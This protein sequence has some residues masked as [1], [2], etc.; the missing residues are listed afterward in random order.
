VSYKAN[1]PVVHDAPAAETQ[2]VLEVTLESERKSI[3]TI[4]A[5]VE[6]VGAVAVVVS[7]L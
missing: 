4:V 5:W 1:A 2:V 3:D 7:L 6:I